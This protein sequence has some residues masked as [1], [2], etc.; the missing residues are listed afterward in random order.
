MRAL[1]ILLEDEGVQSFIDENEDMLVQGSGVMLEF[2][3]VIQEEVM[4]N[5]NEFVEPGDLNQTIKNIKVF[6]ENAVAS[7]ADTLTTEMACA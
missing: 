1:K 7:F 6:T 3:D 5:L 2:A 4:N